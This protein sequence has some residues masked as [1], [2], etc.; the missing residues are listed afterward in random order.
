MRN[1]A[2]LFF[3]LLVILSAAPQKVSPQAAG[4]TDT[5]QPITAAPQPV[6]APPVT[7]AEDP[8]LYIGMTLT[9]LIGQLGI[10][11]SV[12]S[13]R[14]LQEWQDDVVFVY[15]YGDFYIYGDRVWQLAVKSA[16][17]IRIG[18]PMAAVFLSYGDV[19]P[20][21]S[22]YAVFPL[23]G[24]SWPLSLRFNSDAAGRVQMIF[25]YRSD[26]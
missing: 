3:I 2:A 10:P 19:V 16:Y 5:P 12:Y 1:F 13:S 15:D 25:I 20:G 26:L 21:N 4:Q 9:D 18:D 6:T 8:A 17:L 11:R 23:K 22:D 24:Y 7:A 14:G